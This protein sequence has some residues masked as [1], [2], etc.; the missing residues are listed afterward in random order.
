MKFEAVIFDMDGLLIDSQDYWSEADKEFFRKRGVEP[1]EELI[2]EWKRKLMGQSM[3]EGSKK[4]KKAFSLAES[5]EDI[6]AER[7]KL[8]DKIYTD[9]TKA[10]AGA[11]KL[12]RYL[13]KQ[14]QVQAIASGSYLYRIETVVKRFG[15]ENLFNTL[16]SSDHVGAKGKPA[17]DIYLYTAKELQV[18]PE[19]CVVFEDAK[20]GI[21]SAKA[22][23]MKCIAIP[24]EVVDPKDADLVVD[25]LEDKRIF[26]YLGL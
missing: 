5:V 7:I 24:D 6:V 18:D 16:V 19:S 15:W 10:F 17:P 8:T 1:T 20:N 3:L 11:D 26:E 23:G 25:S 14:N 13:N 2:T 12:V 4:L 21:E 22:A 9:F